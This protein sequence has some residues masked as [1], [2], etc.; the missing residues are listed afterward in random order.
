[1]LSNVLFLRVPTS[2]PAVASTSATKDDVVTVV[3]LAAMISYASNIAHLAVD[4]G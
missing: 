3:K 4:P 2:V 1:M